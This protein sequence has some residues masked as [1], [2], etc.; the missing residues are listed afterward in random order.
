MSFDR[1]RHPAGA[2]A[3]VGGRF[4]TEAAPSAS[5][6]LATPSQ[7][8]EPEHAADA[9]R[10]LYDAQHALRDAQVDL[11]AIAVAKLVHE[12]DSSIVRIRMTDDGEHEYDW[13]LDAVTAFD[14]EGGYVNLGDRYDEVHGELAE[15][16][17]F[18][19]AEDLAGA[20]TDASDDRRG[21]R[22]LDIAATAARD[23]AAE[24]ARAHLAIAT[25]L[26]ADAL[27]AALAQRG[28]EESP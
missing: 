5:A 3:S 27:R 2:P 10:S 28:P 6:S 17:N 16:V 21:A 23:V 24:R 14:A 7:P 4:A 18:L 22:E 25:H 19:D 8:G 26:D 1:S 11:D 20:W 15:R 13:H 9:A 12:I